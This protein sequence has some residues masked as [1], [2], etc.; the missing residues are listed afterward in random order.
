M[1]QFVKQ[2]WNDESGFI[3]SAELVIILTVAVLA[4][5][6]GLSYVQSA[7]ISEMS[8][9]G[10]AISS[11]NQNYAYTGFYA[12]SYSGFYGKLKSYYS[13][14]AYS[15]YGRGGAVLGFDGCNYMERGNYSQD[16]QLESQAIEEPCEICRPEGV[17]DQPGVDCPQCEIPD[18][19]TQPVP[20]EPKQK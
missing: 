9:V 7:V 15:R 14:S 19:V 3:I 10:A 5:I 12:T 1:S 8:D 20:V 4:M 13:G 16:F 6:V 17:V 11:L 18:G 2:F